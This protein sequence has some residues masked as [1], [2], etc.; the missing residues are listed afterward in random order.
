M[1]FLL[2][3]MHRSI[4]LL[5]WHLVMQMFARG[6]RRKQRK[7][8]GERRYKEAGF[9]NMQADKRSSAFAPPVTQPRCHTR[10]DLQSFTQKCSTAPGPN[11]KRANGYMPTSTMNIYIRGK[12][13][14]CVFSLMNIQQ[15]VYYEWHHTELL[16][17]SFLL[18]HSLSSSSWRY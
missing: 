18:F 1:L 7:R 6:S 13:I 5:I 3:S 12:L 15:H 4:T 8:D 11:N 16:I 10:S 2:L 14:G 17:N 9:L